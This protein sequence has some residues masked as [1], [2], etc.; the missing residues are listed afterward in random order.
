MIHYGRDKD[1]K[2]VLELLFEQRKDSLKKFGI[3]VFLK[4]LFGYY[5][6]LK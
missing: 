6:I 2:K 1:K 5:G 4:E 3:E